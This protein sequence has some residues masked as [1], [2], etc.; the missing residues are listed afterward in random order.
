[1]TSFI[2]WSASLLKSAVISLLIGGP[3][4]LK[5]QICT[6]DSNLTSPAQGLT[7]PLGRIK[8]NSKLFDLKSGSWYFTPL[9]TEPSSHILNYFSKW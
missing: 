8:H 9:K 1:M 2:S 3:K 6:D 5:Y 7:I 4:D